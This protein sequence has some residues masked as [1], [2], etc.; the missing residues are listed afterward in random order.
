MERKRILV[1]S[2]Y[3]YPEQFR[4]NDICTEWVKK[5]YEVTVVTGIPNYPSGSFFKGYSFFKKREEI[6]KGTHI[7][8]LPIIPRGHNVIMLVLNY[9][10][11]VVSGW[12]WKLFTR[13]QADRVFIFEVSPMTQALVGV[14]FAKKRKIPCLLYVQD[15]WPDNVEI[16]MGIHNKFIISTIR[17]MVDYIYKHCT[18]IFATSESFVNTIVERNVAKEKVFY[19][20]QYAE[21]FYHPVTDMKVPEIPSD[22][23]FKIIFTGNIGQAQGLD[24]LPRV[25]KL[26]KKEGLE[27]AVRFVLV[28]DGRYKETLMNE[29]KLMG[30]SAMFTFIGKQ[31]AEKIPEFLS[32]CDMAFLSLANNLLF[33]KTIPAK[34][35][36]YLACGV[37]I[38]ACAAGETAHI[39]TDAEVGYVCKPGDENGLVARIC[40][41]MSFTDEA[42]KTMGDNARAYFLQ[43]FEKQ[44]LLKQM[45]VYL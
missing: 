14:W 29:V 13:I 36:S 37:P 21:E 30:V 42:R 39:I 17:R 32:A 5:G 26:L 31:P 19:W 1:V 25:A 35:Q 38:L 44:M 11:F 23:T 34:L 4:I 28:G 43:H 24:I 12:I 16:V 22:A 7:V 18:Q 20:P 9:L 8:R 6:Y 27:A 41:M 40:E 33:E 10:S 45:D 15:L 3:F 2:Q